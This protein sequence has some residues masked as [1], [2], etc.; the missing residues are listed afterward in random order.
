MVA[1]ALLNSPGEKGG[2]ATAVLQGRHPSPA[3]V[4]VA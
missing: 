3:R 1:T 2:K 4:V